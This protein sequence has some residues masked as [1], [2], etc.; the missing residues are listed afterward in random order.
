ML[1]KNWMALL[2]TFLALLS[3]IY[4]V[5]AVANCDEA[6]NCDDGY[7]VQAP[8][9]IATP[10]PYASDAS[11]DE[12][13]FTIGLQGGYANTHWDNLAF[14]Q[15]SIS[16]T[17][18]AAR[19]YLGFG[20]NRFISVESG[21]IYLPRARINDQFGQSSHINNYA[22]DLLGKLT[23]PVTGGLD[24][25]AKA[26]LGYFNSSGSS[27]LGRTQTGHFGPA[28]GVGAAYE[29]V[30]NLAIDLSWM[31]YSGNGRIADASYQPNPDAILLGLSYKLPLRTS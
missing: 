23:V 27:L 30:P 4:T 21:Y 31:R 22:V 29:V 15:T 13:Y 16:S 2:I 24:L 28:F 14:P 25:F 6:G 19:G 10:S 12:P 17:G 1:K 9:P 5:P 3:S 20:F 11:A 8:V 18:F 7:Y 26:G